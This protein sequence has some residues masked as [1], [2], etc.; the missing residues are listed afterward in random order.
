MSEKQLC[1]INRKYKFYI[2]VKNRSCLIGIGIDLDND[3]VKYYMIKGKYLYESIVPFSQRYNLTD[4]TQFVKEIKETFIDKEKIKINNINLSNVDENKYIKHIKKF[5]GG[6][7]EENEEN[8][9]NPSNIQAE[10][11]ETKFRQTSLFI[12]QLKKQYN[13]QNN[14]KTIKSLGQLQEQAQ[15]QAL[16]AQ[17]P[18]QVRV[19]A[20]EQA[21]APAPVQEQE[22][23]LAAQGPQLDTQPDHPPDTQGPPPNTPQD[24]N[25]KELIIYPVVLQYD[26]KKYDNFNKIIESQKEQNYSELFKTVRIKLQCTNKNEILDIND[27][28]YKNIDFVDKDTKYLI[29][30]NNHIFKKNNI[31]FVDNKTK[32][33]ALIYKLGDKEYSND[34]KDLNHYIEIFDVL[35]LK[36]TENTYTINEIILT[37]N[38]Q[39]KQL[40]EIDY[41][42]AKYNQVID[43]FTNYSAKSKGILAISLNLSL[44]GI[45]IY[46]GAPL[47]LHE[48]MLAYHLGSTAFVKMLSMFAVK[49]AILLPQE[50]ASRYTG[51][52]RIFAYF[53]Q[54]SNRLGY[55][56]YI[57]DTSY[58]NNATEFWDFAE[59]ESCIQYDANFLQKMTTISADFMTLK[60]QNSTN[61]QLFIHL[62]ADLSREDQ[63]KNFINAKDVFSEIYFSLKIGNEFTA[64][65]NFRKEYELTDGYSGSDN[66]IEK[67]IYILE[68]GGNISFAA[69]NIDLVTGFLNCGKMIK[70]GISSTYNT[71]KE[72]LG[73]KEEQY[74]KNKFEYIQKKFLV[75]S[76]VIVTRIWGLLKLEEFQEFQEKDAKFKEFKEFNNINDLINSNIYKK[77]IEYYKAKIDKLETKIGSYE[78]KTP[79]N[80][81]IIYQ[82]HINKLQNKLQNEIDK[83]IKQ[84]FNSIPTSGKEQIENIKKI[85]NSVI[86][87]IINQE[88]EEIKQKIEEINQ[89][90]TE[91]KQEI[92]DYTTS[93]N[94]KLQNLK[95]IKLNKEKDIN[96][97]IIEKLEKLKNLNN[98]TKITG[99]TIIENEIKK[100]KDEIQTKK[101]HIKSLS[102]SKDEINT[103]EEQ[104]ITFDSIIKLPKNKYKNKLL[105][106]VYFMFSKFNKILRQNL[107]LMLEDNNLEDKITEDKITE[108]KITVT[109]KSGIIYEKFVDTEILNNILQSIKD[110]GTYEFIKDNLKENEAIK[111]EYK[112]DKDYKAIIEY[113][114]D[115][116]DKKINNKDIVVNILEKINE[117]SSG[118]IIQYLIFMM[119]EVSNIYNENNIIGK[120]QEG[121]YFVKNNIK[122]ELRSGKE[123]GE[124]KLIEN[125]YYYLDDYYEFEKLKNNIITTTDQSVVDRYNKLEPKYNGIIEFKDK[126][127]YEEYI[128]NSYLKRIGNYVTDTI[129]SYEH[130]KEYIDDVKQNPTDAIGMAAIDPSIKGGTIEMDRKSISVDNDTKNIINIIIDHSLPVLD[131]IYF[132]PDKDYKNYKHNNVLGLLSKTNSNTTTSMNILNLLMYIKDPSIKD[133]DNELK[134]KEEIANNLKKLYKSL[135]DISGTKYEF[136]IKSIQ[137]NIGITGVTNWIIVKVQINV[138]ALAYEISNNSYEGEIKG[139]GPTISTYSNFEIM[140]YFDKYKE[141]YITSSSFQPPNN[142]TFFYNDNNTIKK[143]DNLNYIGIDNIGPKYLEKYI[144]FSQ[145]NNIKKNIYIFLEEEKKT[146]KNIYNLYIYKKYTKLDSKEYE[147]IKKT[148]DSLKEDDKVNKFKNW[149]KQ[150]LLEFSAPDIYIVK[151]VEPKKP[152]YFEFE[153]D[154]FCIDLSNKF[155]NS[156]NKLP[157]ELINKIEN[158]SLGGIDK[159]YLFNKLKKNYTFNF[160]SPN[161][162]L[163]NLLRCISILQK[164]NPN[165]DKADPDIFKQWNNITT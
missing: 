122:I 34:I 32:D 127:G 20:Q 31:V 132:I 47:L 56:N 118:T 46:Y 113:V 157:E 21:L 159:K 9:E 1:N 94:K 37:Y 57:S 134:L 88:I 112:K 163:Q 139:G 114:E 102:N 49:K 30:Q 87:Q 164:F 76:A 35:K 6:T 83:E 97:T 44:C 110:S 133:K 120:S 52:E 2:V 131:G 14:K 12:D 148:I 119:Y 93:L 130:C 106:S 15:E 101:E 95:I 22:Q 41:Y 126:K 39:D 115:K 129:K 64:A 48:L 80:E 72:T 103:S 125:I 104:L 45:L 145:E 165:E 85:E 13:L 100:I 73:I 86:E 59:Q 128:N 160:D 124:I 74:E 26:N 152:T 137:K 43:E 33:K 98:N 5:I 84:Q 60:S 96:N 8:E 135:L 155:H 10:L 25:K 147:Y 111:K 116:E 68:K 54:R 90:I 158:K 151:S 141:K 58:I 66:I 138:D 154:K 61:L 71:I 161:P 121:P 62:L 29:F 55:A 89:E 149:E 91:I 40:Y 42:K 53:M 144:Q 123:E 11:P 77:Y 69:L 7:D 150:T 70:S 17:V 50:I 4:K 79:L 136:D 19:P 27:L 92:T 36:L 162:D 140:T 63:L 146:D 75:I 3:N 28:I 18:A 24:K 38:L 16:A 81:L 109:F 65:M 107:F 82:N 117:K 156:Y 108:D 67:M 142:I 153:Y 78:I 99:K 143:I 23:A 51:V 105:Y